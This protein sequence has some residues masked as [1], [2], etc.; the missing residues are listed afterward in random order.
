ME[1]IKVFFKQVV[2]LYLFPL[3][4][5][6]RLYYYTKDLFFTNC[7]EHLF[8]AVAYIKKEKVDQKFNLIIDIGAANGDTT[9]FF[10]KSFPYCKVFGY[11][12]NL[13]EYTGAKKKAEGHNIEFRNTALGEKADEGVLHIT[14]NKLSSSLNEINSDEVSLLTIG[15]QSLIKETHTQTVIINTLDGDFAQEKNILLMKIDTQGSEI[16][17]LKGGQITLSKTKFILLEMNNHHI[18]KNTCQYF[19]VD[20]YLREQGFILTQIYAPWGDA[21]EYD[22]LY[23]N[24]RY[25]S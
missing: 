1:Y 23:A 3:L 2:R 5:N 15:M 8:R 24:T 16:S 10:A 21:N 11:E 17:I 13:N 4:K 9:L 14:Q 18:Y 20:Q 22:A 12:P 6:E 25:A 7:A 19:E